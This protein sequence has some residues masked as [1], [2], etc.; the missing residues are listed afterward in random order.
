MANHTLAENPFRFC[1]MIHRTNVP[2]HSRCPLE[3]AGSGNN[4]I[5]HMAQTI[6]RLRTIFGRYG[7]PAQVVT[8]NR[9]QFTSTEFQLF[10]KTNGIKHITTAPFHPATNGQAERFVQSFERA[11]KCEKQ[12]T[13][14]LNTNMAKFLLAYRNTAHSTTEEAP[15]VLF[16]GRP[17]GTR[18]DLVKPDL[19]IKV[20]NRQLDQVRAK[21]H[22][23]TR[24]LSV[25][26]TVMVRNYTRKDKWLQGT[27]QAKTGPLS[28]EIKVGPDRIWRRHIDQLRAS[29]VK[30]NSNEPSDETTDIEREEINT[31]EPRPDREDTNQNT[32][33]EDLVPE[34]DIN[35][36]KTAPV[37]LQQDLDIVIQVDH[38]NHPRG[39]VLTGYSESRLLRK[40][41]RELFCYLMLRLA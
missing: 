25:G 24:Q 31:A 13:S 18:L 19:P 12:S 7:V 9:S 40:L 6:D 8:D 33:A 28:Y 34:P 5:Y 36:E 29:S 4:V 16:L 32:P 20:K 30:L 14:Q 17:L 38:I 27:V 23:P 22:A 21:E 37:V 10:L 39:W 15:S 3:V 1:W 41:R 2:C 26:R 35:P 11:I